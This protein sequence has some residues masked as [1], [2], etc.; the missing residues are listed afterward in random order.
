[1]CCPA[2]SDATAERAEVAFD[3]IR[4]L[5]GISVTLLFSETNRLDFDHPPIAAASAASALL[6]STCSTLSPRPLPIQISRNPDQH[7]YSARQR[8]HRPLPDRIQH[9]PRSQQHV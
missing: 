3:L 7:D 5:D 2:R 1:M 6:E 9:P 8:L 4:G